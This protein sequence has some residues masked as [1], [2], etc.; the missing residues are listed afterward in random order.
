MT[1]GSNFKYWK[2]P[3]AQNVGELQ[4]LGNGFKCVSLLLFSDDDA[5]KMHQ[6]KQTAEASPVPEK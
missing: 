3:T 5:K 1:E 6:T 4:E 2:Q